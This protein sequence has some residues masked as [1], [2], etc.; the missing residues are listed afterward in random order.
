MRKKIERISIADESLISNIAQNIAYL[1]WEY[2]GDYYMEDVNVIVIHITVS[3]YDSNYYIFPTDESR[4]YNLK[5]LY[6]RIDEKYLLTLSDYD[7]MKLIGELIYKS[8][9]DLAVYNLLPVEPIDEAYKKIIATDF[10]MV[11]EKKFKSKK[12]KHTCWLEYRNEFSIC[13]YRLGFMGKDGQIK[14]F[15]VRAKEYPN[16]NLLVELKEKDYLK[17]L[18]LPK[19]LKV[20]GWISETEFEMYWGEEEKYVFDAEKEEVRKVFKNNN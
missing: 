15:I 1:F 17:W 6:V 19:F 7:K 13:T 14:Y 16:Y 9:I 5:H 20:T 2:I 4:T 8:L 10:Y 18:K 11:K 12:N 3:N